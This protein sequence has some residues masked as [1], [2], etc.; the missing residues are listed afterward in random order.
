MLL[1]FGL[2]LL[3]AKKVQ[4]NKA[5]YLFE[6]VPSYKLKRACFGFKRLGSSVMVVPTFKFLLPTSWVRIRFKLGRVSQL[7]MRFTY[8][9]NAAFVGTADHSLKSI[10]KTCVNFILFL[11]IVRFEDSLQIR[12]NTHAYLT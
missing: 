9:L 12:H 8:S 2:K 5:P 7:K 10:V 4:W 3:I 1:K 11:Q 6:A